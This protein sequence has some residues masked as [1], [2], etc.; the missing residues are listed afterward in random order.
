MHFS[1]M[2]NQWYFGMKARV[3]VDAGSGLVHT[4]GVTSGNVHDAKVMVR[5]IRD[6]DAVVYGDRAT[7]ATRRSAL[8]RQRACSGR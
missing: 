8:R 4:A 1:K 6:Y 2:G 7:P 3:G 5:L